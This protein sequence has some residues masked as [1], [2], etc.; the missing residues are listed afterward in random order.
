MTLSACETGITDICGGAEEYVGLLGWFYAMGVPVWSAACGQYRIYPQRF[1]RAVLSQS[2]ESGMNFQRRC[3]KLKPARQLKAPEV[4]DYAETC[5]R[6]SKPAQQAELF[7]W[8][9]YY[10]YCRERSHREKSLGTSLLP[11]SVHGERDVALTKPAKNT[12]SRQ[13]AKPVRENDIIPF[14][15]IQ[16]WW[17]STLTE[18]AAA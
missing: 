6:Q 9:N 7:K 3:K 14:A 16:K 15:V 13:P 1:D 8:K 10:R 17:L 12:P 18:C 2:F 11:G 4:V 5:Y